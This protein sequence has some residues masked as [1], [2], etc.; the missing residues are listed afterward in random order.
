MPTRYILTFKNSMYTQHKYSILD[1]YSIYVLDKYLIYTRY[2][3][4]IYLV[5]TRW[6]TRYILNMY[7]MTTRYILLTYSIHTWCRCCISS[8]ITTR[9]ILDIYMIYT[10]FILDYFGVCTVKRSTISSIYQVYIRYLSSMCRVFILR[11]KQQPVPTRGCEFPYCHSIFSQNWPPGFFWSWSRFVSNPWSVQTQNTNFPAKGHKR[12]YHLVREWERVEPQWALLQEVHSHIAKGVPWSFPAET[13]RET[14]VHAQFAQDKKEHQKQQ[15]WCCRPRWVKSLEIG[16][17]RR[18]ENEAN[19]CKWATP[20]SWTENNLDWLTRGD[21]GFRASV[22]RLR[23]A[24][25]A[26]EWS[27]HVPQPALPTRPF[28]PFVDQG[29]LLSCLSIGACSGHWSLSGSRS[30]WD[31]CS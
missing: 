8:G 9:H 13:H 23:L 12:G 20:W 29:A 15:W 6:I 11:K 10:W 2:I 7:S 19:Q 3:P 18:G 4:D 22:C 27:A 16:T 31:R 5:Y 28:W 21:T 1:T 17:R 25:P 24:A 26:R 30:F 14:L